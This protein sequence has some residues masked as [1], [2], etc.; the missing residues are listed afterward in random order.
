[1]EEIKN[2]LIDYYKKENKKVSERT[3]KSY[4]SR[5]KLIYNG[6]DLE[7]A[8]KS[9]FT[10]NL[11]DAI[12]YIK[13]R[14]KNTST[15]KTGY[16]SLVI[17]AK[18]MGIDN[19]IVK[20]IQD[21]MNDSISTYNTEQKEKIG[22]GQTLPKINFSKIKKNLL[23]KMKDIN[24]SKKHL[25]KEDVKL[26]TKVL[27]FHLYTIQAPVRSDYGDMRILHEGEEED[28]KYNYVNMKKKEFIFNSYKTQKKYGRVVI[29]FRKGMYD[30]LDK[31]QPIVGNKDYLF[32]GK[33]N[34]GYTQNY[35]SILINEVFGYG[36][37][38]LRKVY[39]TNKYK[40][41]YSILNDMD[42]DARDM[43]HSP[44]I[45]R[46]HYLFNVIED[47]DKKKMM[48]I[49]VVDKKEENP[50]MKKIKIVE[51]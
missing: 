22:G 16:A 1:M 17:L 13:N 31:L 19:N 2:I 41:I 10:E 48:K 49:K 21:I 14:W 32:R 45:V 29:Q 4:L 36:I 11:Q 51:D 43:L 30:I 23:M 44:Q 42:E 25:D 38:T 20:L 3:I 37:S 34:K 12:N 35:F 24:T 28:K 9:L 6:L 40:K 47:D 26:L 7:Y 50:K 5:L 15:R 46:S 39:L 33:N 27:I 18:A 8:N